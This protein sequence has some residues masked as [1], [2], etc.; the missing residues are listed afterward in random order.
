MLVGE[1]FCSVCVCDVLAGEIFPGR[2]DSQ[3]A[4]FFFYFKLVFFFY[5]YFILLY[6]TVLVLP[7]I[8]MNLAF[9]PLP[10]S[11]PP[12][13]KVHYYKFVSNP[14]RNPLFRFSYRDE[15]YQNNTF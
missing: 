14:D 12:I 7:Y 1:I 15:R 8:D 6:N 3:L 11:L 5:F 2:K 4:E 10:F 13:S 9:L